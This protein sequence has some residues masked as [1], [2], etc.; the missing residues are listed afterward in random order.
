MSCGCNEVNCNVCNLCEEELPTQQCETPDYTNT[1]CY[2]EQHTECVISDLPDDTCIG[3]VQGEKLTSFLTKLKTYVKNLLGRLVPDETIAIFPVGED[4]S[5]IEE[6]GIRVNISEDEGNTIEKRADGLYSGGGGTTLTPEDTDSIVITINEDDEIS[7]NLVLDNTTN[8]GDNAAVVT[9]HGLYVPPVNLDCDTIKQVHQEA[10]QTSDT[11]VKLL[12]TTT[13]GCKNSPTPT[14][15]AVSGPTRKSVFGF[16]EFFATLSDANTSAT[17]GETVL[18]YD[19]STDNITLKNGVNYFGIGFKK[20]GNIAVSSASPYKGHL[21]NLEIT[22]TATIDSSSS[23]NR[24][25]VHTTNVKVNGNVT[26]NGYSDWFGGEFKDISKTVYINNFSSL[27]F[28]YLERPVYIPEAGKI[29]K[30]ITIDKSSIDISAAMI[31]A[32]MTVATTENSQIIDCTVETTVNTGIAAQSLVYPGVIV[33]GNTVITGSGKGIYYHCGFQ[34]TPSSGVCSNNTVKSTSGIGLEVVKTGSFDDDPTVVNNY[35]FVFNNN[36][37]SKTNSGI[38]SIGA[39][40]KYCGG[41][42][43]DGAGIRVAGSDFSFINTKLENCSGESINSVGLAATRNIH[44]LG[45]AYTSHKYAADGNPILLGSLNVTVPNE[46][47][48]IKGA[49]L[50]S[51]HPDAYKIKRVVTSALPITIRDGGNHFQCPNGTGSV[52]GVDPLLVRLPTLVDS[53]GNFTY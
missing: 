40:L 36:A 23:S 24:T 4:D 11:D 15:F 8:G 16:Q 6:Y 42:S 34:D 17:S 20:I 22:G 32:F 51:A 18:L 7:A 41:M 30:C 39:S 53:N 3:T 26:L 46:H 43:E 37:Y 29:K 45:G 9:E 49:I 1:G 25:Q 12:I 14:G 50:T 38:H 21:S 31:N 2:P 28:A 10:Y 44:V 5:C 27:S 19:D 35:C 33:T 47:Y 48:Y 52:A 13:A